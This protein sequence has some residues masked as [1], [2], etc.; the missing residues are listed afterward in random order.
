[1]L[2]ILDRE[3][4]SLR[5]ER[6]T[7]A[8]YENGKRLRSVPVREL[9]RVV[10]GPRVALCAG[11]LG[12][13]SEHGVPLLVLN[14]RHPERTAELLAHRSGNARRRL[15]QYALYYDR[16]SRRSW[17][18]DLIFWKV[19][20]Q[21]RFLE[22]ALALRPDLRLPLFHGVSRLREIEA[23]L[24]D[25]GGEAGMDVL[26]GWEGCAAACYFEAYAPLFAPR[27][28]FSG[29]Q[30][31]PP[32]DPVN[33]C[34]SLGYVLVHFEAACAARVEGLD[35][36]LGGFHEPAYGQDA[37][38][39]DLME[40][41]RAAVDAWVWSLFREALLRPEHFHPTDAGCRLQNHAQGIFYRAYAERA[42]VWR[43]LLRWY[44][45]AF[46]MRLPDRYA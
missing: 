25:G 20:N 43:R 38:A 5:P 44:A 8:V 17:A 7:L 3:N 39:S 4:L 27:L 14:H 2:L 1:M 18:A 28:G 33:A 35:P 12:L 40:P 22:K 16:E 13:L 34:L 26:R 32:P 10:V 31:R 23:F 30:R 37:L 19:R 29:R 11:V 45:R 36:M 24:A 21:R 15:A 9:E 42:R 41:L 6:A 46:A